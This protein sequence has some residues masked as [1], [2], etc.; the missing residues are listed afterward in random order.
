MHQALSESLRQQLLAV[1]ASAEEPAIADLET[2]P[3]FILS[4]LSLLGSIHGSQIAK[5]TTGLVAVVDDISSEAFIHGVSRWSS[6]DFLRYAPQY[7]NA[8]AID[9]SESPA[10]RSQMAELCRRAGIQREDCVVAQAQLGMVSVYETVTDYRKKTLDRLDDFLRLAERFADHHSRATLYANLLFRLTYDRSHML[11]TWANPIEEYFSS[12][13]TPSTFRLGSKEHYCDCGAFQGPIVSKFLG[14]TG[15]RYATITAYEPDRANFEALE[16]ISV[17]PLTNFRPV[18]KAVSS[19]K[20]MLRFMET[21]TVS[22]YI[23]ATGTATVQTVK[24]DEE[25]EKL[26]FLKM[27]VEGFESKTLQG[28][29][30]LL[31]TQRPRIAACVY[32]YAH[33]LLDV[34]NQIDKSVEDYNLRLRQHNGSYYYDLVLYA[35]PVDGVEAPAWAA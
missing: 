7:A 8:V 17:L 30:R 26:T 35:S 28:A 33:D 20:Q 16:R 14:A 6:M 23:S 31:T 13:A 27:D 1:A 25:L 15:Y 32:H 22:S 19:R 11:E 21:G 5:A 3:I 34:V 18:N 2:R 24:L 12:Y 9:F 4:P 10:D 29:A